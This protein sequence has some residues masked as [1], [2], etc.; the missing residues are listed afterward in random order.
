MGK[1]ERSENVTGLSHFISNDEFLSTLFEPA[2]LLSSCCC[3]FFVIF[4]FTRKEVKEE[5]PN[6]ASFKLS[7]TV[8]SERQF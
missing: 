2:A 4:F 3:C 6:L 5:R 7:A 8:G 1:G